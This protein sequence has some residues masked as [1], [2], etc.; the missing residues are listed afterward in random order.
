MLCA[1]LFCERR[2]EGVCTLK[3]STRNI[4]LS[5]L[6][7]VCYNL[8]LLCLSGT[9]IQNFLGEAGLDIGSDK[10]YIHTSLLQAANVGAILLFS[11]SADR[12]NVIRRLALIQIPI[13]LLFGVYVPLCIWETTS[14][15]AFAV[16]VGV[17]IVQSV[18]VALCTV[19][20]YKIPYRL[21]SVEVYG[22]ATAASG[23]AIGLVSIGV[24]SLTTYLASVLDYRTM[25]LWCFLISAGLM[26]IAALCTAFFRTAPEAMGQVQEA[27]AKVPLSRLFKAPVFHEMI[28]P[29]LLRGLNT[30]V[31]VVLAVVAADLG[32][33]AVTVTAMVPV[34]SA[35]MLLGCLFFGVFVKKFSAKWMILAGSL[36]MVALPF[37]FIPNGT[38]FLV[39]YFTVWFG[40][41]LIDYG[42]P[43]ALIYHVPDEIA[44]PYHAWRMILHTGG[45]FI[46]SSLGALLPTAVLIIAALVL[47]VASGIWYFILFQKYERRKKEARRWLEEGDS[48]L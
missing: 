27:K 37:M 2:K 42:V 31:L 45:S 22:T 29:N 21:Y 38:L 26:G 8:A 48:A 17:G 47:Q 44:G 36:S 16:A 30:G 10:I 23:I 4:I 7:G 18:G 43:T 15:V 3:I 5:I 12:G 9:L 46:A 41:N 33:D 34:G 24:G 6:R 35:A 20:D 40:K 32:F 13:A 1:I 39:L 19:C 11:R 25:M 14:L 28:A